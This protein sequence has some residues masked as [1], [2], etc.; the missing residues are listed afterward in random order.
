MKP[1]NQF[2]QSQL[3]N[4]TQEIQRY[5]SLNEAE[6][7]EVSTMKDNISNLKDELWHRHRKM[8]GSN[9]AIENY[10]NIERQTK[11]LESKVDQA[12]FKLNQTLAANRSLREDI[13][14]LREERISFEGVYKKVE[15]VRKLSL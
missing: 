4:V 10:Q 7:N 3:D 8:G 13:D 14:S 6:R 5:T 11:T 9:A 2:E 12:T 15:K 1:L